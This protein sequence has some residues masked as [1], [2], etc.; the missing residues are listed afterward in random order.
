MNYKIVNKKT[1]AT[2]FLNTK[3]KETFFKINSI[4]EDGE[5]KYDIYNLS[6]AKTIRQAK[7]LD[8]VAHLCVIAASVLGTLLYI[9]NYC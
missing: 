5:F 4:Y 6:K 8:L 3:E 2:Q 1:G 7:M 9:Q